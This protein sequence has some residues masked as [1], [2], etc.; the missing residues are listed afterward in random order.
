MSATGWEWD[1]RVV[2]PLAGCTAFRARP[3]A[4]SGGLP[5][6]PPAGGEVPA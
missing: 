4:G 1:D 6:V 5:Y 2:M 3:A